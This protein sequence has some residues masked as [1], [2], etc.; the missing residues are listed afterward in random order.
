MHGQRRG[1]ADRDFLGERGAGDHGQRHVVTQYFGG[2]FMQE[3]AATRLEALGRPRHAGMRRP[4]RRQRVQGFG[5]GVRRHDHQHQV[6]LTDAGGEVGGGAQGVRQHDAGQVMR[7]FVALVDGRDARGIAA[8]EHGL[9][10][11]PGD[12]GRERGAPGTGTD[13]R[14][15][16]GCWG[17]HAL[18]R[19]VDGQPPDQALPAVSAPARL[20]PLVACWLARWRRPSA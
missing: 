7:V 1:Q 6:G 4:I 5:E 9:A 12:Q 20:A 2:D 14:D 10:A 8:P 11:V 15:R 3:A 18:G 16:Y 19:S 13:D 17:L